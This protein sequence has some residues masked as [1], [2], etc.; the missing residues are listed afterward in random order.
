[1][2]KSDF[3]SLIAE[4]GNITKKEAELNLELILSSISDA[5]MQGEKI[6]F[7]G[8]GSF[9][10]KE[11]SARIGRNPITGEEINIAASKY[12]VFKAGKN[13]KQSLKN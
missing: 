2:K 11:R 1:M 5:L 4:K 9:E 12:P 8:F 3:I 10:V 13:L 7:L 6:Q